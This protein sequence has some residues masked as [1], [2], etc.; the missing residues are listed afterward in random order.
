MGLQA[1]VQEQIMSIEVQAAKTILPMVENM[2]NT[3]GPY[4][5]VSQNT[6]MDNGQRVHTLV[7]PPISVW[8][9][10][11][12]PKNHPPS[13]LDFGL[14]SEAT[15]SHLLSAHYVLGAL[16][17]VYSHHFMDIPGN[18]R[19]WRCALHTSPRFSATKGQTWTDCRGT[20]LWGPTCLRPEARAFSEGKWKQGTS[21]SESGA[22]VS[23]LKLPDLAAQ[24]CSLK[25]RSD[26]ITLMGLGVLFVGEFLELSLG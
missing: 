23:A 13:P 3:G 12:R 16:L 22:L 1:L 19:S 24:S 5:D 21:S 10:V 6:R 17:N 20:Q 18:H 26:S 9:P 7:L 8:L 2:A 14:P 15:T 4:G 11:W 25:L